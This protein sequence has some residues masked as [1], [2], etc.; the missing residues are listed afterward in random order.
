[1]SSISSANKRELAI[2]ATRNHAG[3]HHYQW[4]SKKRYISYMKCRYNTSPKLAGEVWEQLLDESC[5]LER[6]WKIWTSTD[7]KHVKMELE[8]LIKIWR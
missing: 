6:N 4:L 7:D 3:L 1:M 8:I 2:D 5:V